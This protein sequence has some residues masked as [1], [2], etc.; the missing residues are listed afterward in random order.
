MFCKALFHYCFFSYCCF[1]SIIIFC[2][3]FPFPVVPQDIHTPK[4]QA[5]ISSF[6]GNILLSAFRYVLFRR[7]SAFFICGWLY[8]DIS[9]FFLCNF[10]IHVW[11]QPLDLPVPKSYIYSMQ[12]YIV[13]LCNSIC[14]Q[15]RVLYIF[16]RKWIVPPFC[17]AA[18][19]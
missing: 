13:L 15:N 19:L 9:Q 11:E 1:I 18:F 12:M 2:Y 16:H 10:L 6:W 5:D 3:F 17:T 14:F 8:N 4:Y 7:L